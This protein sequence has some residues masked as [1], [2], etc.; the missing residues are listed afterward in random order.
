MFL[1][2]LFKPDNASGGHKLIDWSVFDLNDE[3]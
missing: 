2:L 1:T 3:K